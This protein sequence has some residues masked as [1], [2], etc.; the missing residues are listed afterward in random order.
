MKLAFQKLLSIFSIITVFVSCATVQ[1]KSNVSTNAK[2]EGC[3]L[4]CS[5]NGC[6]SIHKVEVN[7][8]ISKEKELMNSFNETS[9]YISKVMEKDYDK[10]KIREIVNNSR[11][12]FEKIIPQIPYIGGDSNSL[13]EDLIFPA[14]YL[15]Y[16]RVLKKEG[17]DSHYMGELIINSVEI[18]FKPY[19]LWLRRAVGNK[20]FTRRS[21]E[22]TKENAL[23]SQEMIWPGNWVTVYVEPTDDS[24][25][26][27]WDNLECGILKFFKD[28]D[29]E[30]IV[31]Y[32]C[33]LD[34]VQAKGYDMIFFRKGT[35]A[36]GNEKCDFRYKK[37]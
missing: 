20:M 11:N 2:C 8:Y 14:I 32:F 16:Y 18:R 24:F 15:A 1:K 31:P 27:G 4:G 33:Q 26:I 12:E 29:A 28:F 37:K 19:P 6:F 30:E 17:K 21:I 25:D 13:T 9:K 5:D 35:L 22:K 3:G 23:Q 36:N 34:Y 7:Y 10:L